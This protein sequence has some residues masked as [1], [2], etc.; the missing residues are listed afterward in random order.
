MGLS[1]REVGDSS[2]WQLMALYRGYLKA[3]GVKIGGGAPSDDD[4]ERAV[5]EARDGQ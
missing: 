1:A 4:F 5:R 2:I 3:Q